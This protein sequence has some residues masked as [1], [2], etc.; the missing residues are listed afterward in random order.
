LRSYRCKPLLRPVDKWRRNIQC[1]HRSPSLFAEE[2]HCWKP[3]DAVSLDQ[4]TACLR[5][6]VSAG[7]NRRA[8]RHGC[9]LPHA[10]GC[11]RK[12]LLE[13]YTGGS[14]V[15]VCQLYQQR[16]ACNLQLL[17]R[18]VAVQSHCTCSCTPLGRRENSCGS[19]LRCLLHDFLRGATSG[20]A[21][22]ASA[23]AV[24]KASKN[25][26]P[27]EAE[28]QHSRP[29]RGRPHASRAAFASAGA[30]PAGRY[31]TCTAPHTACS[32]RRFHRAAR[33]GPPRSAGQRG[34]RDH[35]SSRQQAR[36]VASRNKASRNHGN[37]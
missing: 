25:S 3:R 8:S 14:T 23:A 15:L 24:P 31:G 6:C 36:E 10:D 32:L 21:R 7:Q 29:R 12:H 16:V 22:A 9:G 34:T 1:G 30:E 26:A 28:Q 11:F 4:P 37:I 18:D 35:R 20:T 19:I 33:A 27:P 13:S 2:Q 5:A 17:E